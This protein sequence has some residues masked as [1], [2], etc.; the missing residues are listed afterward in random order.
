MKK[1]DIVYAVPTFKAV[2]LSQDDYRIWLYL[3]RYGLF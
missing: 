1:Y 3:I 2:S